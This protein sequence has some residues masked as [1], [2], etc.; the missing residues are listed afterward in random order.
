[1][2]SAHARAAHRPLICRGGVAEPLAGQAGVGADPVGEGL[3][4]DARRRGLPRAG[5]RFASLGRAGN[6]V[7]AADFAFTAALRLVDTDVA[8]RSQV[9]VAGR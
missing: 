6:S 8:A 4:A 1:M 3:H 9:G 5:L 7:V 2:T